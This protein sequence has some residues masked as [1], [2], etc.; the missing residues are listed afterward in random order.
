[1]GNNCASAREKY[2]VNKSKGAEMYQNAKKK[3]QEKL[4]KAKE[5][6]SAYKEKA[7]E[8]YDEAKLKY[9]GYGVQQINDTSETGVITKFEFELP[10]TRVSLDEFERRVKK[11][12]DSS[13]DQG[14]EITLK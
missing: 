4:D 1:M 6:Y 10:L 7:R 13:G 9:K 12:V 8:K 2:E 3:T 11:F 5:N 14:E